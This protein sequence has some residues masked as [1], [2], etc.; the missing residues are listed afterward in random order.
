MQQQ[1]KD[2]HSIIEFLLGPVRKRPGLYLGGTEIS[3]L[4]NFIIGFQVG[5][6][7][8]RP[9]TSLQENRFADFLGWYEKTH[10]V[11]K[12]SFW[13]SYFLDEA[14]QDETIALTIFFDRLEEYFIEMKNAA[15]IH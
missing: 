8:A 5:Y 2:Y 3:L 10:D 7:M 11:R 14:N 1:I 6:E 15:P 4:P 9:D 12:A 13:K